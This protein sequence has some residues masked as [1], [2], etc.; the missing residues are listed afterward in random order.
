MHR[1]E[2]CRCY[3]VNLVDDGFDM[4]D[5]GEWLTLVKSVNRSVDGVDKMDM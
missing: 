1:K 5:K 3:L 2:S 4:Y